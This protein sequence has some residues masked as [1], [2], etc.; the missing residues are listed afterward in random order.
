M[1]SVFP[2]EEK[3]KTTIKDVLQRSP[4][5]QSPL[6]PC[7]SPPRF[8]TKGTRTSLRRGRRQ[9]RG[10]PRAKRKE[11]ERERKKEEREKEKELKAQ[12]T[13]MKRKD[14]YDFWIV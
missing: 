8:L 9:V 6:S 10:L 14:D 4:L 13:T 3:K 2:K 1:A 11:E 5:H 12:I 7:A